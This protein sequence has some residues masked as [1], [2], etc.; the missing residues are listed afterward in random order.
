MYMNHL[1]S[2]WYAFTLKFVLV[3]FIIL[4]KQS[5]ACISV[6]LLPKIADWYLATGNTKVEN[7]S[8]EIAVPTCRSLEYCYFSGMKLLSI[9]VTRISWISFLT[10]FCYTFNMQLWRSTVYKFL[11]LPSLQ[12]LQ[13]SNM[14]VIIFTKTMLSTCLPKLQL[15][16]RLGLRPGQVIE[17]RPK[18]RH[19]TS[20]YSASLH[21]GIWMSTSELSGRPYKML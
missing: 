18:A 3:C 19:F 14:A 1:L 17:L 11:F 16:W 15:N 2:Q 13:K 10:V 21:S 4:V 12:L 8:N 9:A 6:I 20:T 5:K 7:V